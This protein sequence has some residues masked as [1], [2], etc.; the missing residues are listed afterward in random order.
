METN[1]D[2]GLYLKLTLADTFA[3]LIEIKVVDWLV[4][5]AGFA[6]VFAFYAIE[7]ADTTYTFLF[8]ELVIFF[9]SV[10]L[11]AHLLHVKYQLLPDMHDSVI[12]MLYRGDDSVD[13]SRS[14]LK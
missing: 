6:L 4:M 8:C 14:G 7:P 3:E 9:A 5:W 11:Q 10:W 12:S 13:S 1:F 2:F